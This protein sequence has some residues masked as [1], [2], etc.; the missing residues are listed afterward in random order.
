MS[1]YKLVEYTLQQI[2][3]KIVLFSLR[4]VNYNVYLVAYLY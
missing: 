2:D 3:G 1:S 4:Y